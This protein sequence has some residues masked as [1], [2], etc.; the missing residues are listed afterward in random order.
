MCQRDGA[1]LLLI[2]GNRLLNVRNCWAE[3]MRILYNDDLEYT[4]AV[5]NIGILSEVASLAR[6]RGCHCPLALF[7]S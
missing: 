4:L 6:S 1:S 5:I 2:P 7:P 3:L